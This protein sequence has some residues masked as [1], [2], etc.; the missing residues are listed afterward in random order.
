MQSVIE[1]EQSE[2]SRIG[3]H[4]ENWSKGPAGDVKM[5]GKDGSAVLRHWLFLLGTQ[6]PQGSL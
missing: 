6:N 5:H 2:R 1:R 3:S 4:T